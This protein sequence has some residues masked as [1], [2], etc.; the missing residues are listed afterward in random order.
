MNSVVK[1]GEGTSS[2]PDVSII[3]Q[4]GCQFA[5]LANFV[6]FILPGGGVLKIYRPFI[7][8]HLEIRSA[9][10]RPE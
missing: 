7:L 6:L 5:V 3:S 10:C 1:F 8:L 9:V 2:R 4:A